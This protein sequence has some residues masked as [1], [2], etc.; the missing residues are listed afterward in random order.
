LMRR[1]VRPL[2]GSTATLPWW[3]LS[4]GRSKRAA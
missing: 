4:G 2:P 1:V 3:L